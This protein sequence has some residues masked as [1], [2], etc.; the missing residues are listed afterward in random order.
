M[1]SLKIS[2]WMNIKITKKKKN[3]FVVIEDQEKK[4]KKK[5]KVIS[6]I[7]LRGWQTCAVDI[8]RSV[9]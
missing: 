3:N 4:K 8:Q 5:P 2:W 9:I 1:M 7:E 6:V